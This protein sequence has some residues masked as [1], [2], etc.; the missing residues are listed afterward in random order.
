MSSSELKEFLFFEDADTLAFIDPPSY[1]PT[2]SLNPSSAQVIGHRV[3]SEKL[4]ATGSPFF[5]KLFEPRAQQRNIRRRGGLP[6]GIKYMI[7][8]TPPSTDEDAVL[9]LTELSCPQ[10]IRTW[11]SLSA[12]W[13]LP[14]ACVG[15]ND[16]FAGEDHLGP[17]PE[18]SPLRHRAG[19]VHILQVLEGINPQL[20]T[21][22][23]LWTFFAL[24]KLYEIATMPQIGV[25]V[26]SWVYESTNVRLIELHPEIT[27][28]L[29]KGTQCD[30]LLMDSFS[31]LVGEEALLLLRSAG[32]PGPKKQQD[33]V[34]GRPQQLLDDDDVQRVQ[35]GGESF[36]NCILERFANFAGSEMLWL[37]DSASFQTVLR[38]NPR[39]PS[40][41]EVVSD[42][43]S[44]L[45]DFV[46]AVIWDV[47]SQPRTTY[48]T[49]KLKH[50]N[51][52]VYPTIDYY[53]V[54]HLLDFVERLTTR[55]FWQQLIDRLLVDDDAQM[56]SESYWGRSLADLCGDS[57]GPLRSQRDAIIR[58]VTPHELKRKADKFNEIFSPLQNSYRLGLTQNRDCSP[59]GDT[60]KFFGGAEQ[61]FSVHA[62]IKEAHYYIQACARRMVNSNR[63]EMSYELTDTLTCITDKEIRYLPLWAGGCDDGTGGVYSDQPMLAESEGFSA[64]GPSIH[65]GSSSIS[66][67]TPSTFSFI[68]STVHGASHRA[69]EGLA[70]EVMSIDSGDRSDAGDSI[71]A[72]FASVRVAND[73]DDLDFM[74]D[75][76]AD[77]VDDVSFDS[78]SDDTVIIDGHTEDNEPETV[79]YPQDLSHRIQEKHQGESGDLRISELASSQNGGTERLPLRWKIL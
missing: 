8:L 42:L 57:G 37:N 5:K 44:C 52:G 58:A 69:T 18:Y 12:R 77:D 9:H 63:P 21:P 25:R 15:G 11:A 50:D 53:N 24:A 67:Y 64:P 26:A 78:D 56:V 22:C 27:Y 51:T 32:A 39:S 2:W 66:S 43:I 34:H 20:D 79:S 19:I 40:E 28:Q 29:A 41:A 36:L 45:K 13:D 31:V 4:L 16:D 72:G 48:L 55:T 65:T 46:R 73:T 49:N 30:H 7:D 47:L 23:K 68:E 74:I 61:Y 75:S 54:Y 38:F 35:Y 3:H 60:E 14:L 71:A 1:R 76:S 62:F 33:T 59:Y 6:E 10:G 17:L 70:S